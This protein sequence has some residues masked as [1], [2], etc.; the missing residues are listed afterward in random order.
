MFMV[1]LIGTF[2]KFRGEFLLRGFS[3]FAGQKPLLDEG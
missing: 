3:Q 1:T 2:H